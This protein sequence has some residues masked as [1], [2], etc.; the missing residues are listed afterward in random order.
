[1]REIKFSWKGKD[2]RLTPSLQLLQRIALELRQASAGTETTVSLASKCVR[3]GLEPL[4]LFIPLKGFMEQACGAETPSDQD[5]LDHL[6][7]DLSDALSFRLAYV[8]SVLP[9]MSPG[10]EAAV[11]SAPK[12]AKA[13]DRKGRKKRS[14]SKASTSLPA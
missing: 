3:G 5:L 9:V 14:T 10:K 2:I 12:T 1:M 7:S 8:E 4:F 13:S 6:L 11:P